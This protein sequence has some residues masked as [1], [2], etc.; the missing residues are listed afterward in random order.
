M[1]ELEGLTSIH[2]AILYLDN[3]AFTCYK[4]FSKEISIDYF[5]VLFYK[6]WLLLLN[7]VYNAGSIYSNY[8]NY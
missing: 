8:I 6:P 2:D 7:I 4:A 3:I 5:T 1:S